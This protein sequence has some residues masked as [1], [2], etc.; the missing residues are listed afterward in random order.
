MHTGLIGIWNPALL[1]YDTPK[2]RGWDLQPDRDRRAGAEY[3]TT[4]VRRRRRRGALR[5]PAHSQTA[6]KE[7]LAGPHASLLTPLG[8]WAAAVCVQ[9]TPRPMWI[10]NPN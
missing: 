10:R 1:M 5:A 3:R 6:I 7:D 9:D 2:G 4:R 8:G